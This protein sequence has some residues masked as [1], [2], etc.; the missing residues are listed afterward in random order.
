MTA[1][2]L[3][4]LA[5]LSV[6]CADVANITAARSTASTLGEGSTATTTSPRRARAPPALPDR[7]HPYMGTDVTVPSLRPQ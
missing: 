5:V 4:L 1:G 2:V 7:R 3:A 6:C